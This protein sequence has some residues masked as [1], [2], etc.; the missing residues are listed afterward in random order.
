MAKFGGLGGLGG[1]SHPALMRQPF[2]KAAM[3]IPQRNPALLQL[4]YGPKTVGYAP[5][6]KVGKTSTRKV[7]KK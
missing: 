3:P 1:M 6:I 5:P 4:F 2:P 7:P